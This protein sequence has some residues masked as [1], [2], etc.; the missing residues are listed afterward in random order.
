MKIEF[1]KFTKPNDDDKVS[2]WFS[3][4]PDFLDVNGAEK[5]K[6]KIVERYCDINCYIEETNA[7]VV[8]YMWVI[9]EFYSEADEAAFLFDMNS[10]VFNI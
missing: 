6:K 8:N 4:V 1:I 2:S 3:N 9:V 5:L 7:S 10:G